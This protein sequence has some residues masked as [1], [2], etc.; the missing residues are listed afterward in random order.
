[1]V[2][3]EA[4]HGE[5]DSALVCVATAHPAKFPAAVEEATGVRPALPA[6][7][8]DLFERRERCEVLPNDL[9]TVQ[10]FVSARL[11]GRAAA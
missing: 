1:M 2:A 6:R 9:E 5:S 8:A 3:G 4:C 7:M 11:A 10:D